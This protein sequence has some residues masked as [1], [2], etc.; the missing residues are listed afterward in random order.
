MKDV[1]CAESKEKSCIR[2]FRFFYFSSYG[3]LCTKTAN[4][5]LTFTV[6]RKIKIGKFIFHSI[7]IGVK[8]REEGEICT[9][10]VGKNP[11]F[12]F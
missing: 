4:F 11:L 1:E 8:L 5:R 2:F 10:L 3:H 7:K 12:F 6:N 9:A